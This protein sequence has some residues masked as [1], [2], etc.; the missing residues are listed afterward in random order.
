M[1]ATFDRAQIA[2][3]FPLIPRPRPACQPLP[4]RTNAI[5]ALARTAD[6]GDGGPILLARRVRHLAPPLPSDDPSE[7]AI[8]HD[9]GKGRENVAPKGT[10]TTPSESRRPRFP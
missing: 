4:D 3:R 6:A 2:Q 8:G 7:E 5:G 10:L 9:D 1:D